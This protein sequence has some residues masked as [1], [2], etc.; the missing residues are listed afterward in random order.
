MRV[1]VLHVPGV[2]HAAVAALR[3]ALIET[4]LQVQLPLIGPQLFLGES[5][6]IFVGH[7]GPQCWAGELW[8]LL[9]DSG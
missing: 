6:L 5:A 3:G 1:T 4:H 7:F 9:G 2:A 8:M